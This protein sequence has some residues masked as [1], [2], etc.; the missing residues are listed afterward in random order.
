MTRAY[1]FSAGPA[2]LPEVVMRKASEEFL[3]WNHT[4]MSVMEMSH[5][6]K[7]YMQVAQ[8]MEADLREVMEIPDNYKVLFIH[9]GASL[10]FAA[11]PLNLTQE[12]DTVDY[13][14]TG[15]WSTKAIKE[16]SR[17]VNVNVVAG[18]E[19]ANPTAIPD[20]SEWKF[21]PDAKYIHLCANETIT[22]LEFQEDDLEAVFAQGKP[23]IAD[24]SSNIMCRK[25]DVSKYGMI[26]AGAQKNIGPAGLAIVIVREDLV[27]QARE[28]TPTLMN[29]QVYADNESMFNTPATFAW[30]LA[31]LVFAW[32][33]EI[34][35]VSEIAKINQV[36]AQKLYE[37]IDSSDFYHNSIVPHNR[38]WMNV[39]FS[40]K[41]SDLDAK[42]LEESKSAG[43]LSLKGHKA[44]G[45]MRASIYNAM[46]ES[47]VDALI[48]FMRKFAAENA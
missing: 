8:Q 22:G 39:T 34:G 47:G 19:S 28:M 48:E 9:G 24:M 35:G 7:E 27:G 14:N 36:K 20:R 10:Q 45:G 15:V 26:Y 16:A 21:S 30:Y 13:F 31:G 1:N 5:R 4:G 37:Y 12:G 38:S 6:S 40:L 11:I 42:F 44:F 46:P 17:Y 2:M 33:K 3:N 29:W 25:I 41:D 18:G 43:L 23:V 32:I